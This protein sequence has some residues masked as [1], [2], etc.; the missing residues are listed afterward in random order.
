MKKMDEIIGALKRLYI[1]EIKGDIVSSGILRNLAVEGGRVSFLLK[2]P[3]SLKEKASIIKKQAEDYL[4]GI[5]GI[6]EIEIDVDIGEVATPRVEGREGIE[7]RR[8]EGVKSIL[9]VASGKG[10]VGKSTVSANLAVA[11]KKL[12]M[13]VALLDGDV[14]GPSIPK[15]FGIENET[16][17]VEGERIVPIERYGLKILSIGLMID[18][19]TPI[20]WRGPMLHKALEQFLFDTNWGERDIMLVDLP[21][22]TGD[23]Q[24]SVGQLVELTGGIVVTTPQ[25][26]SLIDVKRAIRMF[27]KM[28]IDVLGVIE[29]MS[30]FFCPHC[31]KETRIF[32]EGGGKKLELEMGVKLLGNV[33]IDPEIVNSGDSGLPVVLLN[34]N[35]PSSKAF[36]SIAEKIK[37]LLKD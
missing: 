7:K 27:E 32:G 4:K 35:S 36:L 14:Y 5:E 13:K 9:A 24:I 21:P 34:E 16:I 18:E 20:I 17:F 29:N 28:N 31:G 10:G 25:D 33:P 8:V 19:D 2:F 11:L 12:G 37:E 23:A 22:G 6:N 15:M 3:T 30:T 1:P 26:I